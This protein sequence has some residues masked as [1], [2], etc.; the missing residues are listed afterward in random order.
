MIAQ[1]GGGAHT[2]EDISVPLRPLAFDIANTV[3]SFQPCWHIK[4][5]LKS[6]HD[7]SWDVPRITKLSI[8]EGFELNVCDFIHIS[9]MLPIND[10]RSMELFYRSLRCQ[11]EFYRADPSNGK[12]S[13][14]PSITLNWLVVFANRGSIYR[15]ATPAQLDNNAGER[16]DQQQ[17]VELSFFLYNPG[18]ID[19]RSKKTAGV[20]RDADVT[21]MLYWASYYF[22]AER[23]DMRPVQNTE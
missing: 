6:M 15:N 5:T 19:M 20:F 7:S 18:A 23:V 2:F 11:L 22:G 16:Y 8:H 12:I 17:M 1:P 4:A 3:K 9:V 14:Q 13:V 10:L 21:E